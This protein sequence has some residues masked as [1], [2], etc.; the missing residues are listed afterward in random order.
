MREKL[1]LGYLCGRNP[2]EETR[3]RM[4]TQINKVNAKANK[5]QDWQ[6]GKW[7]AYMKYTTEKY[8]QS[9]SEAIRKEKLRI[10]QQKKEGLPIKITSLSKVNVIN[11]KLKKDKPASWYDSPV[12]TTSYNKPPV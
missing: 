2:T 7:K 4:Q 5:I 3:K 10:K 1:N 6:E 9:A 8:L 11:P 12:P